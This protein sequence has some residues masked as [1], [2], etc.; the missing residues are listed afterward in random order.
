[1]SASVVVAGMWNAV[2]VISTVDPMAPPT[3]ADLD[4]IADGLTAQNCGVR[5][6]VR[7]L[8]QLRLPAYTVDDPGPVCEDL[9]AWRW[10][11]RRRPRI[12]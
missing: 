4:A 2:E 12:R 3:Q 8:E 7:V 10:P 6:V 1:M 11:P 5:P 9:H